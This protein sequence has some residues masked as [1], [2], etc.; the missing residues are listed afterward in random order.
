MTYFGRVENGVIVLEDSPTLPEGTLVRVEIA[1]NATRPTIAERLKNVIGKG[2]GLPTD[3]AENHDH[4]IHG[5][6]K[7]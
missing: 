3:L 1:D 2:E 4:Y 6:P 7:R 5:M